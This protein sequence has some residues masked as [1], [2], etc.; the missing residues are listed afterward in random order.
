MAA[1]AVGSIVAATAARGRHL[2][3]VVMLLAL[4]DTLLLSLKV[5]IIVGR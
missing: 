2:F 1:L 5:G 4:V 3:P